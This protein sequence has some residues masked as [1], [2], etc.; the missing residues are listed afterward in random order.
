MNIYLI[1][2]LLVIIGVIIIILFIKKKIKFDLF[3]FKSNLVVASDNNV[4]IKDF[5]K[6]KRIY[7]TK[8][9]SSK[10][11]NSQ[12]IEEKKTKEEKEVNDNTD[13]LNKTS[14]EEK[15]KFKL[16][17]SKYKIIDDKM[18]SF[19]EIYKS[20]GNSDASEIIKF[21]ENNN[22]DLIKNLFRD[23]KISSSE[24]LEKLLRSGIIDFLKDQLED[25]KFKVSQARKSGRAIGDAEFIIISIPLKI[26]IFSATFTKKDFDVVIKKL[27]LV[28]NLLIK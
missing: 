23:K 13:K 10:E 6:N 12:K 7:K 15:F 8:V 16:V 22:I 2:S 1:L 18:M 26:K 9:I 17:D 3:N 27:D 20:L 28:K 21:F 4:N 25:L 19:D 5:G 24:E 14:N 11:S